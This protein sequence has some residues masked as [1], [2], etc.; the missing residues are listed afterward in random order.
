[1]IS[2]VT[3]RFPTHV[4]TPSIMFTRDTTHHLVEPSTPS[5]RDNDIG[6]SRK[7]GRK[8]NIKRPKS[9]VGN[10]KGCRTYRLCASSDNAVSASGTPSRTRFLG[11]NGA[12]AQVAREFH[13]SLRDHVFR[14][15]LDQNVQLG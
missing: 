6:P 7:E 12:F 13:H 9:A 4:V 3:T 15:T 1:M 14:V 8:E 11:G 10:A 5:S 2:V